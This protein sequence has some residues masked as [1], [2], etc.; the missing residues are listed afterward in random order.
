MKPVVLVILDGW[1]SNIIKDG[2]AMVRASLPN[3]SALIRSYPNT[4][5]STSGYS[6][7]LPKGQMGNSE[8]GHLTLG[9]GRVIYQELTRI[10]KAVEEKTLGKSPELKA[11]FDK[12]KAKGSALHLLGLLSDGGVHSHIDHL[13]ALVIEAKAAG[14]GS[15]FI[16]AFMDGRDTPPESGKGYMED[17]QKRLAR[18]GAGKVSTVSG[19]F[20]A[21]DRDKRWDRVER[22]YNAMTGGEG[23]KNQDP[24]A[25][26]FD[27]YKRR[28][29][30]EF[31]EPVVIVENG[32]PVGLIKDNDVV[33]FFNFRSDR[34]RELSHALV[35]K[36]FEGFKRKA[37]P[38]LSA[39][40]TM[41]EYEESLKVPAI[42]A[43]SPLKNILGEVLSRNGIKQ[44][45]VSETE[46]YAH[47]TFFFN[48][49]VEKPFDGEDRLLIPSVKD[50]PTYD[51]K[52]EMRAKEIADAA[53]E[54]IRQGGYGFI[55]INFANGDMVGHTGVMDA[56]VRACEAV[57]NA[58]G[59]VTE[60]SRE[61]G[62]AVIITSDHGNVEQLVDYSTGEPH[63]AHTTNL[64]PF[65]LIDDSLKDV[66][67][68][69]G[70]G[71]ADVAPTV[72]K[73]MGLDIPKDMEGEPVF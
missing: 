63:T 8:V 6:V 36:E 22:A 39:F 20:Y 47:V 62:F 50:V 44:F 31:I 11:V 42:F 3:I 26:I 16:H 57:D 69:E 64:V 14:I 17:L 5:I 60:A 4:L 15:I 30:D 46:K 28:V 7:G 29:T 18:I 73:V 40:L 53:A 48:G 34:A 21:M 61:N 65:M 51:L 52:P 12:V 2:N 10:N 1:G 70:R 45:R 59:T 38:S 25:A 66:K 27:S 71:L 49:G 37:A 19:R 33:I 58:V 55:L 54:K 72:L 35:D 68:K 43:P 32:K 41:T 23:A 56:A 13:E 24:V 67:L 9:S